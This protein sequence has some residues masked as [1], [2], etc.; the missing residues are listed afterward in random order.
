MML[1]R[2]IDS[3]FDP[4]IAIEETARLKAGMWGLFG[5]LACLSL[6]TP[7]PWLTAAAMLT[8]PFLFWL[9]WRPGE[10]PELPFAAAFQWLQ[11]A[12]PVLAMDFEWRH[13][14]DQPYG[15]FEEQAAWLS[16]LS[17][18][19]LG[20]G[21]ATSLRG[22]GLVDHHQV[23]KLSGEAVIKAI[24]LRLSVFSRDQ[25]R[26]H[27]AFHARRRPSTAVAGLILH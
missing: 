12:S 9:L 11:A 2:H 4:G 17:V 18:V 1:S 5:V 7:N 22:A 13:I 15:K 23:R 8:P 19:V 25:P 16:L 21:M 20:I 3:E 14:S 26:T 10:P 27:L 6:F 24:V